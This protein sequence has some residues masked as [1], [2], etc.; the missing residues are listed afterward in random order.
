MALL[1]CTPISFMSFLA[2]TTL[3]LNVKL[4]GYLG[5]GVASNV[6]FGDSRTD[7]RAHQQRCKPQTGPLPRKLGGTDQRD[8]DRSLVA[9]ASALVM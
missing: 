7:L 2:L 3:I 5:R 1:I 4:L 8:L 9:V 6:T